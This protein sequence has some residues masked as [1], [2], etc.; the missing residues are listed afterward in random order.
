[1]VL[2]G[3]ISATIHRLLPLSE[4]TLQRQCTESHNKAEVNVTVHWLHCDMSKRASDCR[5]AFVQSMC[6][7]MHCEAMVRA[8][9]EARGEKFRH[10]TG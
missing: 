6:D 8:H 10:Q 4:V 7:L 5:V 2:D 1:M 3:A 9:E